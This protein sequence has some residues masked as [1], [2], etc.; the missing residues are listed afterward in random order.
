M[1]TD[2]QVRL[3]MSLIEKGLSLTGAAA[4]SGMSE[5]TARTYRKTGRLPSE[6]QVVPRWRTRGDPFVEVWSEVEAL[7]E[8]DRGLQAKTVFD[9]LRRRYPD[10]FRDGQVRTLQ[11]RFRDWKA[12]HGPEREVYFTQVHRPGEQ[13]QSDFTDMSSLGVRIAGEAFPHLCYHYVLTY[14]NWEWAAVCYGET[15]EALSEGLQGALWALGGVPG[16][17]RTDNLSAA[18]HE[19]RHSRGRGFTARYR[20]VLAHYGLAA[21]KNRPGRAHE[22]GDVESAHGHF[23]WAVDQ[24]LRLRGSRDFPSVE[25][26]EAFVRELLAERNHGRRERVADERARLRPLPAR[27]LPTCR[28]LEVRVSRGSTIRVV[29]KTY[30]VSSRLM[31]H[32]VQVRVGVTHL[33]VAYQHDVVA[34]MERLHGQGAF[35]INYRHVIHSLVRKPG[36]FRRYVYREALFPSL[37]FR[38][39]Y[40]VLVAGGERGADLEYLRIVHL[41]ATTMESA[42]AAALAELLEAG[43]RPSVD[44]VKARVTPDAV[45]S[46]PAVH[47]AL[48]DLRV[49]DALL[50]HEEVRA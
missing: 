42:V 21:S 39:C 43:E 31:G 5:R 7:R 50:G 41:A 28:E 47:I 36:A 37:V 45:P 33:E 22:N 14:S 40:D 27:A 29:G 44:R 6:R 4:K 17:H 49:Y 10:R 1:V 18:T 48:P 34:R 16:E 25:Q 9:E 32:R 26:Y 46:C 30:S 23:K 3:L 38:R 15:F 2:Q 12:R 19:L 35:G 8:Q 11:R 20:E 13:C 24:Q